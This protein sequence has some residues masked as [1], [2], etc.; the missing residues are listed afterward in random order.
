MAENEAAKNMKAGTPPKQPKPGAGDPERKARLCAALKKAELHA[1]VCT[2]PSEV[3]LLTGY[4]PIFAT[5]VAVLTADGALHAIVPEDEQELASKTSTATLTTY[6]PALLTK[7]TGPIDQLREPLGALVKKL[8]LEHGRL[9]LRSQLGVQPASYAVMTDFRQSLQDLLRELAPEASLVPCDDLL[10]MEKAAKTP[11]E[12]ERMRLGSKLAEAGFAVA[13]KAIQPGLREAEVAATIQAAFDSAPGAEALN[14]SYGYYFC[15]SGPN[16]A[17][18]AAAYARTRQRRI[19]K[20]DLVMI[21]ANTCADGFWTDIT[22]TYTAGGEAVERHEQMR[23]GIMAARASALQAIRPGVPAREVDQA[24]RS[25]M[26]A[27]GFG[28]KLF[29]HATG[30][31]V[32][33]AAANGDALPRIHPDSPDVLAEGMTF[34]VEPAAY[35]EGYGGMRHCDVIA[36]GVN[37]AEVLTDF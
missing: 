19:E 10:E 12:L 25:V 22:R 11:P 5:S 13:A 31:G 30:H 35:F 14:R 6:S 36:V 23:T 33:F 21:H 8:G 7:L 24:T 4:W 29:K 27:H 15:M 20:G 28:N 1:F 2:S 3:L 17:T 26:A 34:N 32:G 9:G 37:G 18:A 16:S